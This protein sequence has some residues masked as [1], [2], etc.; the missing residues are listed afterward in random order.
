VSGGS[1]AVNQVAMSC[2]STAANQI[3]ANRSNS[4]HSTGPRTPEGKDRS[5][6]N[7]LTHGL[8]AKVLTEPSD[9]LA[10]DLAEY[11]RLHERFLADYDP[12]DAL[13]ER[14][15]ARLAL[16]CWRQD[17]LLSLSQRK[18]VHSLQAG[19][20]PLDAVLGAEVVTTAEAKLERAI[21]RTHRDLL[22]LARYRER[23]RQDDARQE[24]KREAKTWARDLDAQVAL[25]AEGLMQRLRA[26]RA[27]REEA[28]P[29]E[30]EAEPEERSAEP[31][32]AAA[33][34]MADAEMPNESTPWWKNGGTK[35]QNNGSGFGGSSS[36]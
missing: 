30:V 36:G 13:E 31:V 17:R 19:D 21:V 27:E 5:R 11:E 3:T 22:F 6:R 28:V 7:A 12:Q 35:P 9:L 33:A 18:L 8:Y 16:L 29:T 20:D 34:D 10:E 26:R 1:T 23:Q 24:A 4:L 2:G 25:E 15:I 32:E 14:L